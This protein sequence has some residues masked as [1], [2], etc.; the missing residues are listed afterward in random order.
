MNQKS[1]KIDITFSLLQK[2]YLEVR[3][4]FKARHI[5]IFYGRALI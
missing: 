4:F 2:D 3:H 1:W 5:L